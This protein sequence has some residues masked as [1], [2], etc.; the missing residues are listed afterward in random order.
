[1]TIPLLLLLAGPIRPPAEMAVKPVLCK[2]VDG[3]RGKAGE[4]LAQAVEAEALAMLRQN[5]ELRALL[6]GDPPVACFQ[7]RARARDLRPGAR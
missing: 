1:M 3:A 5:Y 7:S 6:P 4:E 2:T